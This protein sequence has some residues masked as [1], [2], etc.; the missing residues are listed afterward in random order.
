I[1]SASLLGGKY[2]QLI[3]RESAYEALQKRA[4]S[5]AI[6]G[7]AAPAGNGSKAAPQQDGGMMGS[8]NDFLFGSVGPRG[9]RREGVV[10]SVAKSMV[11]QT[12]TRLVRGVLGSLIGGKR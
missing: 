4:E 5:V 10:Q 8:L 12:A 11:R 9:G 2:E 1:R 6:E 7:D 3:D